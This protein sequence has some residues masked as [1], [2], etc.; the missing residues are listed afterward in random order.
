MSKIDIRRRHG[1]SK[2]EARAAIER[3]TG[4][5]ADRFE[6]DYAW[7]GDTM[8]F[9]RHGVDGHIALEDSEIHVTAKLGFL[10]S[11]LRGPIEQEI[12]RFL[13][14]EFGS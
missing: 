5:V 10:V 14:E 6:V 4:K 3:V 7:T 1:K 13:D 12:H 8:N 2:Q 11:M 9:S